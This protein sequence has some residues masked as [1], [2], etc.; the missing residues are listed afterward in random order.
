MID[1][2]HP[3][4]VLCFAVVAAVVAALLLAL[5][6]RWSNARYDNWRALHEDEWLCGPMVSEGFAASCDSTCL[7]GPEG[8]AQ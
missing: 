2:R 3:V 1:R 7:A 6:W 4:F 5:V 8:G